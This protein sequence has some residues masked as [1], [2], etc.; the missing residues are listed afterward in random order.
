[1]S[2]IE[3]KRV[4]SELAL[5]A[6]ETVLNIVL[7]DPDILA[8]LKYVPIHIHIM[9]YYA[10]LLVLNPPSYL[11]SGKGEQ[12]LQDSLDSIRL[13]KKLRMVVLNNMPIDKA[14]SDKLVNSLTGILKEKAELM[15]SEI[16]KSGG[17]EKMSKKLHR[18]ML[19]LENADDDKVRFDYIDEDEKRRRGK[20]GAKISAWPGYDHGH[21]TASSKPKKVD[22]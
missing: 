1:M 19:F 9:L 2:P 8:A 21:P 6:A 11:N 3:S 15:K 4:S 20:K 13:V 18:E 14:F 7:N 5:T 12:N 17:D 16:A 22:L 10:A